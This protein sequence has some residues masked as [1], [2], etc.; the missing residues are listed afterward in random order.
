M[1]DKEEGT[2]VAMAVIPLGNAVTK[3]VPRTPR[4]ESYE[5]WNQK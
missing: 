3:S 5:V 1:G 2:H 4:A